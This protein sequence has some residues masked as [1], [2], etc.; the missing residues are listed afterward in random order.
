MEHV[1][2]RWNCGQSLAECVSGSS[3]RHRVFVVVVISTNHPR[4]CRWRTIML[5]FAV[6]QNVVATTTSSGYSVVPGTIQHSAHDDHRV[7]PAAAPFLYKGQGRL[8]PSSLGTLWCS[9]KRRVYVKL[10]IIDNVLAASGQR[11]RKVPWARREIWREKE[12]IV[13]EKWS[14][15]V[16]KTMDL[17]GAE[18][19]DK[20]SV[21]I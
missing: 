5:L 14:R 8:S 1:V 13:T 6:W 11:R 18:W 19:T 21:C 17:N 2:T 4:S 7:M 9:F 15:I 12:K 10:K 20:C 3:G 16:L